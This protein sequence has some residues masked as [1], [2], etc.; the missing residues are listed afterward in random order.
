MI[1]LHVYSS[2]AFLDDGILRPVTI[3][4]Y[5]LECDGYELGHFETH[6][7]MKKEEVTNR[8]MRNAL[9]TRTEFTEF[10]KYNLDNGLKYKCYKVSNTTMTELLKD[11][12]KLLIQHKIKELEGDFED[13]RKGMDR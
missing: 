7:K 3:Y 4:R 1:T 2:H 10:Y 13:A 8:I 11:K 12:K 6:E 9:V 5:I